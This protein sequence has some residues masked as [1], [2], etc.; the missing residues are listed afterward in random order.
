[1]LGRAAR[2][3]DHHLDEVWSES[4][5]LD[6][7]SR[8]GNHGFVIRLGRYPSLRTAWVWAH[9]FTPDG[10][11]SF[12][13]DSVSCTPVR[14]AVGDADVTYTDADGMSSFTRAG[15]RGAI[16]E[17]RASVRVD[18]HPG[19]VAPRGRGPVPLTIDA[20]FSPHGVLPGA[21][22]LTGRTEEHGTVS[23]RASWPGGGL[24]L[25][26]LG[27][28]HE[29]HQDTPRFRVPF[30]YITVRGDDA[31]LVA[32]VGPRASGGILRQRGE[33]MRATE[34][35]ISP[36]GGER[37]L[38]CALED[39]TVITGALG[40]TYTYAVPIDGRPRP[41]TLVTGSLDGASVSGCVNDWSAPPA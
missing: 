1:M 13:D 39:G 37:T 38:E 8:D 3:T 7:V 20:T 10:C 22:N 28:W 34:V 12:N 21:G 41:G 11:V 17:G 2:M 15:P 40:R 27:Q 5:Y 36:P 9:V 24:A 18:A 25:E 6:A 31:S 26:A 16:V 23:V 32:I 35:R 14:V 33:G 29:Q 30:T 19:A 4:V